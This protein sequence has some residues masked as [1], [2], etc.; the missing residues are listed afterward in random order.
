MTAVSIYEDNDELRSL[1]R[2]LIEG[3]D[4]FLVVGAYANGQ[5]VVEQVQQD[6]PDVSTLR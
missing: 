1:L 5:Q 3:T 4:D 6:R 2:G